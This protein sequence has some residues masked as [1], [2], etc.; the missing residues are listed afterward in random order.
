MGRY[1]LVCLWCVSIDMGAYR[2]CS[3][4]DREGKMKQTPIIVYTPENKEDCEKLKKELCKL[5]IFLQ[6]ETPV[7][8]CEW[9][10]QRRKN[11]KGK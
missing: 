6:V 5:C 8:N 2:S 11:E 9:K 7:Q 4:Y 1:R 3:H 10:K